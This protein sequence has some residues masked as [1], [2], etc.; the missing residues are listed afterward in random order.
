[1]AESSNTA[2]DS[3]EFKP[4]VWN[5]LQGLDHKERQY[6]LF[7]NDARDVVQG[8]HTL[9][10]L[11]A[12]DEDR[13]DEAHS[14]NGPAPVPLFGAADRASLQRLAIASLGM[15]HADIECQCEGLEKAR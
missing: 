12:W 14:S 7:L 10:E 15:L 9:M 5:P 8:A 13:R 2:H 4:F 1:M 11:L 6:A 3:A